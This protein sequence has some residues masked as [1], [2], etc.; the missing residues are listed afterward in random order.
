MRGPIE[1]ML[2]TDVEVS[3]CIECGCDDWHACP[4]GCSWLRVDRAA[5]LGVCSECASRVADWDRGDRTCTE[6]SQ[7]AQDMAWEGGQ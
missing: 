6:E 4:G 2:D 1:P 5:G 7:M 3:F